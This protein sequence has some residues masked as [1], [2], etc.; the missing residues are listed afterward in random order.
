[1]HEVAAQWDVYVADFLVDQ[2]ANLNCTDRE[3]R[4]P[5][6]IAAYSNH[7]EMIEFLLDKGGMEQCMII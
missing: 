7:T 1:M 4:T 3:G 5:L 2:G 6:H